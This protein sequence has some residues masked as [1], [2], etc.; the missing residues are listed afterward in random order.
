MGYDSS[1]EED[2]TPTTKVFP[3][4]Y[5]ARQSPNKIPRLGDESSADSAGRS[6]DDSGEGNGLLFQ[7]TKGLY[8]WL[9]SLAVV[10][11]CAVRASLCVW[12]MHVC[13]LSKLASLHGYR[14]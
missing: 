12:S 2:A 5:S 9:Q 4:D 10:C 8:Y 3:L 14:A 7:L 6:G 1:S 11:M 13:E